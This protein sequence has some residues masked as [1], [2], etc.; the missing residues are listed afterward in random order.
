MFYE[1]QLQ[2]PQQFSEVQNQTEG[3]II[4]WGMAKMSDQAYMIDTQSHCR[5]EFKTTGTL[6]NQMTVTGP[7]PISNLTT[8]AFSVDLGTITATKSPVIFALGMTRDPSIAYVNTDGTLQP[9]SPYWA[10]EF[11]SGLDAATF[12]VDDYT[13][14][15]DRSIAL[16]Q[17]LRAA[18]MGISAHYADLV[19]LAAR[20]AMGGTELTVGRSSSD[21]SQWNTSDVKMFMKNLGTDG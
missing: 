15:I 18:A 20:Q 17:K 3:G 10:S 21:P 9:R 7:G 12:F 2:N 13:S 5:A 14:A 16:D 1:L 11:A 8:F 4:F 19:S 6:P